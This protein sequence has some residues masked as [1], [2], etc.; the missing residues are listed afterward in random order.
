[1]AN[2]QI[3]Y[4][5][6]RPWLTPYQK[7]AIFND[8]RYSLYEASTKVGKTTPCI[9]WLFEQALFGK[10]GQ[11]YWWIAPIFPQA[12]IA[13]R[14]LN[15]WADPSIITTN[16]GELTIKL[17]NGSVIWFKGADKPDSLYGED[18]YAA[19]VDEA[20]RVKEEAWYAVRSTL[21]ATRG[22]ARI[23]GNVKGRKNWFYTMCRRAESGDADYHYQKV[24]AYDAV[25]AGILSLEEVEDAKR[26]LP[27]SVFK[28]LYL[29]EPSDDGGNPFGMKAIE[30]CLQE[31]P[32]R[33]KPICWGWD[34]AKSHDWCVGVALDCDGKIAQLD[35][36][37][38]P[39]NETIK[40]ILSITKDTSA[41]VDSTGVGDP[42]LEA[43]QQDAPNFEGFKFSATSKQKL[44][45]GL[46]MAIHDQQIGVLS[47]VMKNELDAFEY[48][49]TRTGVRYSAP[50]GL[51]DD[52]V[53]ALALAV[54]MLQKTKISNNNIDSY[55]EY[56][57]RIASR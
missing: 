43:L 24:T 40:H 27:D 57:E 31:I 19:V 21:T 49:Y 32:T 14:R 12:K 42:I 9:M 50:E 20:S 28:E 7:E 39:W 26:T 11:N 46:A 48:E 51:H 53:C 4:I 5:Y 10:A 33:N 13:F 38:K 52:C 3:E 16:M 35:R 22:K 23:I 47:G 1:M 56:I 36:F 2:S 8:K 44:M 45:E 18:V 25:D 29:A 30:A 41:L 37:Q 54:N 15:S 34:L 17:I 55:N 6:E